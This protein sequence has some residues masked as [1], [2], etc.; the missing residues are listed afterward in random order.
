MPR[1]PQVRADAIH[2]DQAL[3]SGLL[4]SYV[5]SLGLPADAEQGL[6]QFLMVIQEQAEN[7]LAEDSNTMDTD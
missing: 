2:F 1:S 7:R 4:A 6:G 5:H 3:R